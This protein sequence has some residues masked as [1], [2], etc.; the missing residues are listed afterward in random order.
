MPTRRHPRKSI[1]RRD[2]VVTEHERIVRA[3]VEADPRICRRRFWP[4]LEA[5]LI[6]I[7]LD[8]LDFD[9]RHF[10]PDCYMI[11]REQKHVNIIEVEVT[12]PLSAKKRQDYAWMWFCW[13][14]EETEWEPRLFVVDRYGH[15][16]ELSLQEMY[17]GEIAVDAKAA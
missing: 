1:P 15:G 9:A 5:L 3:L 4:S 12:C 6:E 17:Y 14:S 10:M 8:P 7:G 2:G 11:D 16:N 13:E